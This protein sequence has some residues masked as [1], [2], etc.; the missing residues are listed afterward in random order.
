M[1][2][3]ATKQADKPAST[4]EKKEELVKDEEKHVEPVLSVKDG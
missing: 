1:S 4:E 3:T 2:S